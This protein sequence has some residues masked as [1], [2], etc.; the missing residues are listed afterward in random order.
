MRLLTFQHSAIDQINTLTICQAY[1][2]LIIIS[3]TSKAVPSTIAC[4]L[5][6]TSI[7]A[8]CKIGQVS[9]KFID[10]II[11]GV[12]AEIKIDIDMSQETLKLLWNTYGKNIPDGRYERV[13]ESMLQVIPDIALRLR[14]TI[15][16]A[17]GAG[18]TCVVLIA[19][20]N[21]YIQRF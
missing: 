18:L 11:S 3:R 20:A 13:F 17:S 6:V 9:P 19:R 16:Q 5:L 1:K 21:D 8:L 12:S 14:L 7:I 10:K 4:S 2:V 15:Q